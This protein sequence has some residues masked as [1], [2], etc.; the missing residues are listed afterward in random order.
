MAKETKNENVYTCEIDGKIA[1][2][3]EKVGSNLFTAKNTDMEI[4]AHVE[5]IDEYTR[6]TIVKKYKYIDGSQKL[7]THYRKWL[8]Y[9][10]EKVG[11]LQPLKPTILKGE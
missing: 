4:T 5:N 6:L 2:T 7:K 8:S 9:I 3:I 10:L 11:F 1:L